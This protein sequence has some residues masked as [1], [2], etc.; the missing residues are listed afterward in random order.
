FFIDVEA[1]QETGIS[2]QD[3]A[4]LRSAGFAT[5]TGVIQATRKT[6]TKIKGLSEIKVEKIK[7]AANKILPQTFITGAEAAVRR[8]KVVSITTGS[9]QFDGMLGGGIQSQS[10]TEGEFTLF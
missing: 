2:A 5:V 6:L 4:K 10:V 8:E 3:I 1:L 7:D 9:R